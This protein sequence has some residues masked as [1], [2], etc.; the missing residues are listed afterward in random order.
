M[1]PFYSSSIRVLYLCHLLSLTSSLN[2]A[3][4]QHLLF[5]WDGETFHLKSHSFLFSGPTCK[6]PI[7]LLLNVAYQRCSFISIFSPKVKSSRLKRMGE[8]TTADDRW[9]QNFSSLKAY[10]TFSRPE[11]IK[12]LNCELCQTEVVSARTK[13]DYMPEGSV[14]TVYGIFNYKWYLHN[15]MCNIEY[16]LS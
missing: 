13:P 1:T 10:G 9:Q 6:T 4:P 12:T 14:T 15:H 8:E 11:R 16:W 3:L 7:L 2:S 5:L